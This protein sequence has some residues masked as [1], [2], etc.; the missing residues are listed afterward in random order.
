[1]N[2][3]HRPRLKC[4][5]LCRLLTT[6]QL[7]ALQA[8]AMKI[9]HGWT[10]SSDTVLKETGL[11]KLSERKEQLVDNFETKSKSQEWFGAAWFTKCVPGREGMRKKRAFPTHQIQD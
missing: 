11:Q 4:L 3:F 1:M 2:Y 7:E 8:R 5:Q 6:A 10:V 9:V